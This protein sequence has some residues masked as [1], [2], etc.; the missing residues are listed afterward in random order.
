LK[1]GAGMNE[2]IATQG[3]TLK[4]RLQ[5]SKLLDKIKSS[6]GTLIDIALYG[7]IGFLTGFFLK[8]YST[9]VIGLVLFI[10]V[11]L[12]LQHYEIINLS[13]AWDKIY[14]LFGIQKSMAS[15]N[16][17]MSSVMYEWIKA[18]LVIAISYALGFFIGLRFG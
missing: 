7:G 3:S 17:S 9:Y 11:L 10:L 13:V 12:L 2:H 8:K 5:L 1:K 16:A 15:T 14:E 6:Q 4:E 18:N